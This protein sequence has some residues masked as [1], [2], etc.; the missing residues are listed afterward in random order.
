[1][2]IAVNTRLLLDG[3]LTGLGHFI[4][5]SLKCLVRDHPEHTFIFLFDRAYDPQ[6]V[7]GTNVIPVVLPPQARAAPLYMIWY[8]WMIPGAIRKYKADVFLSMDNFTSLRLNI[9]NLL[10]IH[11]LAYL[12]Y[13]AHVDA[14]HLWY[15]RR[16]MPR[17]AHR[18]T[19]IATVSEYSRQDILS[20]C[21][22]APDKV[23][24][25]GLGLNEGIKQ[26]TDWDR[27]N[28][29]LQL[30]GIYQPYFLYVG[31]FQP[32][33]NVATLIRAYDEYKKQQ[34]TTTQLVLTGDK[35]WK[36]EE[37]ES[38]LADSPYRDQ[39]I[40]LGYQDNESLS[41]LLC[42]ARALFLVSL[43]EGFGLPV[44]EAQ[45]C[46]C[47]VVTSEVSSMPEA[48]GG[49]ALLVPPTDIT[50]IAAAMQRIDTEPG[51]RADLIKKGYE[52]AASYS[53][54]KTADTLWEMIVRITTARTTT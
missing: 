22:I 32:R 20:Q 5:E 3:R 40:V 28:N 34:I 16:Y 12:H 48:A 29:H 39:I 35:G 13:P 31:T 6:F 11:D 4:H 44:I 23:R 53:W 43:F 49:A 51:L 27:V 45:K 42:G 38:A 15:Y 1:M 50:A 30:L 25:C 14:L 24:V 19:A 17:F 33:K 9:P 37:M 54:Q 47:P 7:L 52:N 18:A 2:R 41:A 36:N 10:V 21:N 8:D 26:I 46:G